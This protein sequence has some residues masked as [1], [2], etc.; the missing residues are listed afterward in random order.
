MRKLN[1]K[2]PLLVLQVAISNTDY[3]LFAEV[4]IGSKMYV[5]QSSAYFKYSSLQIIIYIVLCYSSEL[6]LWL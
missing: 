2:C 1:F 6:S 3:C 4:C 5:P